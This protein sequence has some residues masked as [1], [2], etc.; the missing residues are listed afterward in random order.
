M[1][2]HRSGLPIA[3]LPTGRLTARNAISAATGSAITVLTIRIRGVSSAASIRCTGS[4]TRVLSEGTSWVM[5][6][7][8]SLGGGRIASS[9]G[10]S[11]TA[12]GMISS[13]QV[14]QSTPSFWIIGIGARQIM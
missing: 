11:S 1:L 12:E 9:T 13:D 7:L 4:I 5:K 14:P 8:T 2:G 3:T 10:V 6:T